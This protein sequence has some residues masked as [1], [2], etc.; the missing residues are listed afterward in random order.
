MMRLSHTPVFTGSSSG[1]GKSISPN[2]REKEA[3]V[4]IAQ[5]A[6]HDAFFSYEEQGTKTSA[7]QAHAGCLSGS[8]TQWRIHKEFRASHPVEPQNTT[9]NHARK[10]DHPDS[11]RALAEQDED[12]DQDE[13]FDVESMFSDVESDITPFQTPSFHLVESSNDL[14]NGP[15]AGV[16]DKEDSF[17]WRQSNEKKTQEIANALHTAAKN[18][19]V[20]VIHEIATQHLRKMPQKERLAWLQK[21][22]ADKVMR[23]SVA[24]GS[25]ATIAA[26]GEVVR[27]LPGRSKFAFL[28]KRDENNGLDPIACSIFNNTKRG[29][30]KAWGD[31]LEVISDRNQERSKLLF[32]RMVHDEGKPALANLLERGDKQALDQ[33]V[34]LAKKHVWW[35]VNEEIGHVLLGCM[36]AL[37]GLT[38]NRGRVSGR[39]A[40]DWVRV[41]GLKYRKP[42][43]LSSIAEGTARAYGELVQL[44]PD[45]YRDD[46][47]FPEEI[48]TISKLYDREED[49]RSALCDE[50]SPGQAR[51]LA[52]SITLL[53]A[54]VP[55]MTTEERDRVSNK[56]KSRHSIQ[57]MGI[58]VNT[59]SYE[60]FKKAWPAVDAMLLDLKAELQWRSPLEMCDGGYCKPVC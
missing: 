50:L 2:V 38:H 57:V 59:R 23:T 33:F 21:I 47:L 32:T 28:N 5:A 52:H 34:A 16:L 6:G 14:M 10:G 9:E 11:K 56:I 53:K 18:I 40:Q 36:S 41:E 60:K 49:R 12:I 51:E 26:W 8:R 3:N 7:H 24:K 44:V 29:A 25:P 4:S 27:L 1:I 58:W 37:K 31:L 42:H 30:M 13:W 55:A 39:E 46:V 43:R 15:D 45:K 17:I 22:G 54:M 20:D 35:S 19:H 48:W